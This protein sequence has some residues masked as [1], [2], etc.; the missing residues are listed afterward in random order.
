MN[1]YLIKAALIGISTF[2]LMGCASNAY[3]PTATDTELSSMVA[4]SPYPYSAHAEQA[5]HMF[6]VVAP[7]ATITIFNAGDESY[8]NFQIWVNKTYAL[9]VEKL[10]TRGKIVIA[11]N[12]LFNGMGTNMG[13]AT[14]DAVKNIQIWNKDS[15]YDVQG[16]IVDR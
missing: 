7:D 1:R 12:T 4:K 14:A 15:L 6:A 3:K 10:D 8:A 11:P 16:P 2:S 5:P 9:Q 13:G